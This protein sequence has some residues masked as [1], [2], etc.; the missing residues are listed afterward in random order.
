VS[1]QFFTECYTT[2]II[3]LSSGL[4]L[5]ARA[6]EFDH[7]KAIDKATRQIIPDEKEF[8]FFPH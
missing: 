2:A 1:R 7:D 6:L 8:P 3:E 5:T 4:K